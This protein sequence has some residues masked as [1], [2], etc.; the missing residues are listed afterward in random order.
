MNT[1]NSI[2]KTLLDVEVD[3]IEDADVRCWAL[4]KAGA[5]GGAGGVESW[6]VLAPELPLAMAMV[7]EPGGAGRGGLV[8]S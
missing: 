8:E 1:L 7:K 2:K 5:R 4:V 3:S 6:W